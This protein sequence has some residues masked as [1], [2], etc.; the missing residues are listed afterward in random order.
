M[1]IL[2]VNIAPLIETLYT[3]CR[4]KCSN[5]STPTYSREILAIKQF[6]KKN[7]ITYYINLILLMSFTLC[8]VGGKY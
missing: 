2:S 4:D 7:C 8:G 1:Y 5:P 3:I 6:D